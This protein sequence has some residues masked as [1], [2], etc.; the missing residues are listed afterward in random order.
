[1]SLCKKPE[2]HRQLHKSPDTDILSARAAAAAETLI[3]SHEYYHFISGNAAA[4]AHETN[5]WAWVSTTMDK[6]SPGNK[7]RRLPNSISWA[8]PVENNFTSAYVKKTCVC[9]AWLFSVW[10]WRGKV[11]DMRRIIESQWTILLA[12]LAHSSLRLRHLSLA[13]SAVIHYLRKSK[14][15]TALCRHRT[16]GH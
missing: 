13:A 1:M 5:S 7:I 6:F 3:R 10:C 9:V 11:P 12:A 16:R 4:A 14:I 2:M 15:S 8:A